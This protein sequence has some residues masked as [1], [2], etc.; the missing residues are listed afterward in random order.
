MVSFDA[1]SLFTNVPLAKTIELIL[2][3]MYDNDNCNAVA[4]NKTLFCKF[5]FMATQGFFI[6]STTINSTSRLLASLGVFLSDLL[7]LIFS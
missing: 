6:Y 2:D 1:V 7:Q 4:V 5:M 3:R